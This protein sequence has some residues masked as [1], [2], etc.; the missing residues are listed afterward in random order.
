M[1]KSNFTYDKEDLYK[2]LDRVNL[3]TTNS[4]AKTSIIVS[5][6]GVI[7]AVLL[8]MD[9][10]SR[11]KSILVYMLSKNCSWA[12]IYLAAFLISLFIIGKGCYHLFR[13][14][15]PRTTIDEYNETSIEYSSLIFFATIANS[16]S[17]NEYK[18][19][20]DQATESSLRNDLLSQIYINSKICKEKF[21][22]HNKGVTFILIGFICFAVVSIIG[23]AIV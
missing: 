11:Y 2:T 16:E 8:S 19:K 7:I 17:Y 20:I 21:K 12:Y 15:I 3:W 4:E 14:L 5:A 10:I 22:S 9:Y 6:V 23:L 13:V 18:S 1:D